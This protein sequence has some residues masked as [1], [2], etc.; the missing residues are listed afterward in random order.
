MRDI[1]VEDG[2]IGAALA[3]SLR[4]P[5]RRRPIAPAGE[6]YI[7]GEDRQW[8]GAGYPIILDELD[9]RRFRLREGSVIDLL[10]VAR[11]D[12][13]RGRLGSLVFGS[14]AGRR[15]GLKAGRSQDWLPHLKCANSQ[16][17]GLKAGR[18]LKACPTG[19][20]GQD[21]WMGLFHLGP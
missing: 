13:G 6:H 4:A 19:G 5:E 10:D 7:G 3:V 15:A 14:R 16:S 9:S 20:M 1:A 11:R 2:P 21:W 12:W 8:L 17:A 18:R